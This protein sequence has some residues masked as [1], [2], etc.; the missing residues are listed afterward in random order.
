MRRLLILIRAAL[1]L[2]YQSTMH[3][4]ADIDAAIMKRCTRVLHRKPSRNK[5]TG[6]KVFEE[7]DLEWP[8]NGC[9]SDFVWIQITKEVFQQVLSN[10]FPVLQLA[11]SW[12][13]FIVIVIHQFYI[14]KNSQYLMRFH[15][16]S[17]SRY[18]YVVLL[19][20]LLV[21]SELLCFR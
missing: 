20:V 1:K 16:W 6:S 15:L 7:L 17:P 19:P 4:S 2:V 3:N 18:V 10:I 14:L 13:A 12:R 8:G 21:D 9:K 11:S 5:S